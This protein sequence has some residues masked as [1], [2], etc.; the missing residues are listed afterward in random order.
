MLE[1]ITRVGEDSEARIVVAMF[2]IEGIV[3]FE[4]DPE[5]E[6]QVSLWNYRGFPKP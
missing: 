6:D 2:D 3:Q 4:A 1:K 5:A